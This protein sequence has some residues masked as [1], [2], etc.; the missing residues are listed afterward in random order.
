ML[1]N[2]EQTPIVQALMDLKKKRL[3]P[4]DVPG[5]KRGKSGSD[6]VQLFGE[7][8]VS[9]DANSMKLL[10]NLSHPVSV[11]REAEELAAKL[12]VLNMP[13]LWSMVRHKQCKI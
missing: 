13:F 10:D 2:Q 12:L 5:H 11:I 8:T 7:K 4:F 3:V 6:L 9:I 1:T